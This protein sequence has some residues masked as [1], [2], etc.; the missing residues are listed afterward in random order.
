MQN[1][2]SLKKIGSVLLRL[3]TYS[4]VLVVVSKII[5][6]DM[7]KRSIKEG[8]FVESSQELL[9]FLTAVIAAVTGF[10]RPRIRIFAYVSVS[11]THLTLPTTPYV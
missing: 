3:V 1:D 9:L 5:E 11:Y 10:K 7:L 8:S 4:V 6:V 2:G